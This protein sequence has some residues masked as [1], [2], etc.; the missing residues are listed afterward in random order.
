MYSKPVCQI[1]PLSVILAHKNKSKPTFLFNNFFF[2]SAYLKI[3]NVDPRES[4]LRLN[5][6]KKRKAKLFF[7]THLPSWKN[8]SLKERW[9]GS[10]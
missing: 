7:E 5:K 3:S 10:S 1:F 8:S 6:L 2:G 9:L 4:K